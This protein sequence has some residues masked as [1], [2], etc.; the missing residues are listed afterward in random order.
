VKE[1][2]MVQSDDDSPRKKRR[3]TAKDDRPSLRQRSGKKKPSLAWYQHLSIAIPLAACVIF[4]VLIG[5]T[6]TVR[7]I[8]HQ[9]HQPAEQASAVT[10]V[11]EGATEAAS[12]SLTSE[13]PYISDAKLNTEKEPARPA[14]VT[15]ALANQKEGMKLSKMLLVGPGKDMLPTITEALKLAGPGDVIEVRTNGPLLELG[16]VLKRETRIENAPITIRNGDGFQPVIQVGWAG[17]GRGLVVTKNVDV[18]VNGLHCVTNRTA[19]LLHVERGNVFITGCTLNCPVLNASFRAVFL[20]NFEGPVGNAESF[21]ATIERCFLRDSQFCSTRGA[22]LS[23]NVTDCGYIGL[24]VPYLISC[25]LSGQHEVTINR[26]SFINSQVLSIA[27]SKSIP[28][29]GSPVTYRIH[30]SIFGNVGFTT[31]LVQLV[32]GGP[33]RVNDTSEALDRLAEIMQFEG[34]MSVRELAFAPQDPPTLLGTWGTVNGAYLTDTTRIP[35]LPKIDQSLKFGLGIEEM[36]RLSMVAKD[37]AAARTLGWTLLPDQLQ[38]TSTGPLAE[39]RNAGAQVGCNVV[40]L[41][42]PPPATLEPYLPAQ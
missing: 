12:R 40:L 15:A 26:C 3:T 23:I 18:V 6:M 21:H 30:Q 22:R 31:M 19:S 29:Q 41:P 37:S 38:T 32:L 20:D 17:Y 9:L 35:T 10:P 24:R 7:R 33:S 42:V 14:E 39:L 2:A 28:L 16:T 4:A 34:D 1:I 13:Q 11:P 36:R 25:S 8:I 5:G 27:T